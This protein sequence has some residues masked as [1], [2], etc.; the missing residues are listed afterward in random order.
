MPQMP[1]SAMVTNQSSI[2]GP[3][4]WPIRAVPCDWIANSATRIATAAGTHRAAPRASTMFN[5][6]SADSTE[7]A[8]VIA[9]SP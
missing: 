4:K 5:P 7:I 9:P 8:G 2:T 3:K 1:S 6:F